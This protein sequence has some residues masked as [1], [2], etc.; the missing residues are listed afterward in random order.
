MKKEGFYYILGWFAGDGWFESRGIAIGNKNK[1]KLL[2]LGEIIKKVFGKEPKIKHRIYNDG[3]ELYILKLSSTK[4]EKLFR[5]KLGNV[6]IN[7]SKTFKFPKCN[8]SQSRAFIRGL[9]EAE[10]YKYLWYNKPRIGFIIFN[11]EAILD[12]YKIIKSDEINCALSTLS[13]GGFRIDITGIKNVDKFSD[14]YSF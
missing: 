11:K 14:L 2:K 10:A 1:Q 4:I 8:L 5:K 13:K 9:Y 12:V 6:L 7:K 3:H